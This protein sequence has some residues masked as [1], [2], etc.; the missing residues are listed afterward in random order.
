MEKVTKNV[1]TIIPKPH[2]HPNTM[3]KTHTK[4]QNNEYKTVRGVALTRGTHCLYI[5]V[6]NDQ[7]HNVEKVTKNNLT[8]ISKP[9][10]HLH[11][12][13]K[14]HARF[15]NDRYKTVGR[16]ALTRHPG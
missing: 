6:K 10:A 15:K 13:K 3:K 2:A 16:A 5:E 4:F 14:T 7:V 9:H 1:L 12:M 11:T 8:I